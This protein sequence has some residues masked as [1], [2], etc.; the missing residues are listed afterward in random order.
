MGALALARPGGTTIDPAALLESAR[1]EIP[2]AA[3]TGDAEDGFFP[4]LDKGGG[5]LGWVGS[6]F[7]EA[8]A[9]QGYSGPSELLIVLNPERQVVAVRFL[10]SADTSGHVAKVR[11]D[12]DFW[13][14]WAGM[15]EARLGAAETPRIV[16]GA[17]LT[18][19]A[20][21]R[22]V[23]ARFGASGQDQWFGKTLEPA[24]VRQWFPDATRIAATDT[25]GVSRVFA[26]GVERGLLLRSSR[27]GVNARGYNGPADVLV[28]LDGELVLGVGLFDS[29]DN[30]PYV[31]D[32]KDELRY[33]DG[34][35]GQSVAAILCPETPRQPLIVSG[36][37]MTASAVIVTVREML[38]RQRAVAAPEPVPWAMLVA[39]LWI[40]VGLWAGFSKRGQRPRWR[41][42]FAVASVGAG[43]GLGLMLGQD[44]LIGWAG[45]GADVSKALPLIVLT[46]VALLV[47]ALTGKNVYCSR[48]CP[49]GA[50][51][52]LLGSLRRKRRFALPA[53][54]H[55][56]LQGLPWLTLL[57]I[58]AVA[59]AGLALPFAQA[60]PFEFWSAGFYAVI[61][62]VIFS[63]G[64]IAALF[65]PQA[66]CHYGCP[67]GAL[68]KFLSHAPGRFT[69]RDAVAGGLVALAWTLPLLLR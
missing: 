63:G 64:L 44:Q 11:N 36:A 12:P 50:A 69:R 67:T 25:P 66:Y 23:A 4:L 61:P 68:L 30:E 37:S 54:W 40:G 2:D 45:N 7:P 8:A 53:R 34:F 26:D 15:G 56:R 3:A 57:A 60:E 9:I 65:L 58:W 5:L 33:A 29:R 46:A 52:T 42:G 28:A 10:A 17:T 20:M 43:L 19:E 48:I 35:A 31:G 27:M 41:A 6:T 38:R 16:S 55:K 62:A 14:Q 13:N 24:A 51:Q 32:V 59:L 39:F 21:A 18:S 22:G 49:H 47:P 1:Q